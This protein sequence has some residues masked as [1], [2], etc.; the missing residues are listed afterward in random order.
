MTISARWIQRISPVSIS[1]GKALCYTSSRL[2]VEEYVGISALSTDIR[3]L[4]ALG[5]RDM[6]FD[7]ELVYFVKKITCP[8]SEAGLS[9]MVANKTILSQGAEHRK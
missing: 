9:N 4:G 5:T 7:T 2:S 1:T 8:A 6:A 3:L